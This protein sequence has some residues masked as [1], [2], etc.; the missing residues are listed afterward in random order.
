ML[1]APS[2]LVAFLDAHTLASIIV[3]PGATD[4]ATAA[5]SRTAEAGQAP[6]ARPLLVDV[7]LS[8]RLNFQALVRN[9]LAA[10]DRESVGA[11]GQPRLG[12]LQRGELL[13]EVLRA[14]RVELLLVEIVGALIGSLVLI[15]GRL[16]TE[17]GDRLLDPLALARE[18]LVGVIG[19]HRV[20]RM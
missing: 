16:G 14:A 20:Q 3:F 2:P 11:V 1:D 4:W 15:A 8:G 18:E 13:V 9:R 5:R 19:I 17:V 6:P 10:E 7:A 12:T